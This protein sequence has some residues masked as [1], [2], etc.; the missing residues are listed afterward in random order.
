MDFN[1]VQAGAEERD[2]L[3]ELRSSTIVEH[4]EQARLFLTLDE[5]LN[6]LNDE[7]EFHMLREPVELQLL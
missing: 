4:L 2:F 7:Y 3:L 5:H 1:L 6:R